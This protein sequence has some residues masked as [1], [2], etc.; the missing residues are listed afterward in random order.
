MLCVFVAAGTVPRAVAW[1]RWSGEIRIQTDW[2]ERFMKYAV[3]IGSGVIIYIASF[4]KIG[5]VIQKLGGGGGTHAETDSKVI[6]KASFI[7]SK[8]GK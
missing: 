2:W 8:Y 4:V 5:S 3:E 1:R 7:F 6:S